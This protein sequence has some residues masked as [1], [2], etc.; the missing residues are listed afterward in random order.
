MPIVR[1]A[2][3]ART[4]PVLS[5]LDMERDGSE[6]EEDPHSKKEFLFLCGMTR[7]A[8]ESARMRVDRDRN[9]KA[10]FI[11]SFYRRYRMNS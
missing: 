2:W 6:Q 7:A 11:S 10:S 5:I 4:D 9:T 3:A 8:I 1:E